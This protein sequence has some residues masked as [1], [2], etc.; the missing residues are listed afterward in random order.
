MA[1]FWRV[2]TDPTLPFLRQAAVAGLLAGLAF[3][4]MG[5]FVVV[6]RITYLAGAIAHCVLGG[7]G[8]ALWLRTIHGWTWLHPLHGAAA[9][10]VLAA[11][12][13]GWITLRA[14]Q[15]EDTVIGALW[16]V[17]MAVGLLFLSRTP[18]YVDPM[19]YLFGNIL[20]IA[21]RDL[22]LIAALDA[23][24][25]VVVFLFYPR[26]LGVC[27]DPVFAELRGVRVGSY[28]LLLL[29]L[30]ALTVV[31]LVTVVGI[32]LVI[33]L[34]TLPA[35]I[36]GHFTHRLWRMMALASVLSATFILG[37]LAVSYPRDLPA[38]AT[39]IVLA[40]A[41]YLLVAFGAR[42]SRRVPTRSGA[43]G[44]SPASPRCRPAGPAR[45]DA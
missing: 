29:T 20:M 42:L 7:I 41:A 15:R 12:V 40:A 30:T 24:V 39:I 33:A 18:S 9:S 10:A 13:I 34:L 37:G 11:W 23:L 28:Y 5:T 43:N 2:L 22:R 31:F 35:A 38:G 32:I 6:R 45:E 25:L 26:L 1:E 36:A 17:G 3:G 21:P 44:S 27:F 4:V 8:L 14:Q 19:S 16:A